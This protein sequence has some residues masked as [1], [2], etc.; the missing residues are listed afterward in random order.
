MGYTFSEEFGKAEVSYAFSTKQQFVLED[1]N[2]TWAEFLKPGMRFKLEDGG[3]ATVTKVAPPR[4]V[5][6]PSDK[7][8][9]GG[10]YEK[11]ILGTIKRTGLVVFDIHFGGGLTVTTTPGHPIYSITRQ[12]F[13]PAGILR[14]GE[15]LSNDRGGTTP[16][17]ALS[18]PRYGLVELY[19]L[20]VEDF[21]TFFVGKTGNA[22]MVHNGLP[23]LCSLVR[24]LGK[25]EAALLPESVLYRQV[26]GDAKGRPFGTPRNTK[27]PT[28]EDLNP[29]IAEVKAGDLESAI[30]GKKHGIFPEQ[31]E[32]VKKMSNEELLRFRPEDPMSGHM[33]ATG[34][35]FGI[36]GGHHRMNEII[37]R[38]KDGRLPP[39]T[40]IWILFHD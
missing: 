12:A 30:V 31:A 9:E 34:D 27:T 33:N 6:P 11:R 10:L 13:V 1:G 23:G 24:P 22:V 35:G 8:Y 14:P 26:K 21:H 28:I 19:N 37:E 18:E 5:L 32:A 40:P 25:E 39:D 36:T 17:V 7:V 38:V 15:L 29:K 20:E 3:V 2:V 16:V 4:V